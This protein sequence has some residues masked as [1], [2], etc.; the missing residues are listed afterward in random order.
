[1]E[2]NLNLA[3][4]QSLWIGDKLS[5]VEQLCIKSFLD[6]GHEFHLYTYENVAN[7]PEGTNVMNARHIIEEDKIFRFE[8]GWG[9]GSVSGFADL[10]RLLLLKKNGGWWVDMDIICLKPFVIDQELVICTSY[11]SNYGEL[12]NNCVIKAPQESD[13]INYCINELAKSDIKKLPFGAAGPFLF[14]RVVKEMK[15]EAFLV[16]YY[17]FNPI[18][19]KFVG[20]LVLG[21]MSIINKFKEVLRPVFKPKTLSGR[22]IDRNSFSIHLWNEVWSASGF[23][24]NEIYKPASL[25]EK[26]KK[27]HQIK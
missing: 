25:F 3:P 19:W 22:V 14:Q 8:D 13:F 17:Y 6:A 7:V 26:I 10:F 4:V 23:N 21:K 1:M 27:R 18:A 5:K 11:E 20:D 2:E 9:K 15:L 12:A 16:P 24:K